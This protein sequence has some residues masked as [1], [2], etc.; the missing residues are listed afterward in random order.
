MS[1]NTK[2][3]NRSTKK[4]EISYSIAIGCFFTT[5]VLILITIFPC[6][7]SSQYLFFRIVISISIA[8]IAAAIPGF[9]RIQYKNI[10]RAGGALGV[11][12]LVYFYNPKVINSTHKC[13]EPL[14]VIFSL[15]K[16]PSLTILPEYPKLN[17]LSKLILE[18]PNGKTEINSINYNNES[19]F[20]KIDSR[21]LNM[22]VPIR[23]ED[24]YW[25]LSQDSIILSENRVILFIRPNESLRNIK[26]K[27]MSSNGIPIY[28]ATIYID[29]T[30]I[31][32]DIN[33]D[34]KAR[35]PY[36][37]LKDIYIIRI[38][39]PGFLD[40]GCYYRANSSMPQFY[41]SKKNKR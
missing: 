17:P 39:V 41:L 18:L 13:D 34:Y 33:G 36:H 32:T 12:V 4:N 24:N 28:N 25:E 9:F 1:N 7:S 21:W 26:G 40:T 35:L 19:F 2:I 10:I 37:R 27:V 6:P 38:S 30:T 8:G 16:D 14:N 20:P 22:R 15:K 3:E 31:T 11:F 29:D 5:V 23:M